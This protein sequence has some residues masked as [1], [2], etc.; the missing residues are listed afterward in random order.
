VL[1]GHWWGGLRGWLCP[2][3][4]VPLTSS[5]TGGTVATCG[6][7]QRRESSTQPAAIWLTNDAGTNWTDANGGLETVPPSSGT[8]LLTSIASSADGQRLAAIRNS[9]RERGDEILLFQK[10]KWTTADG[11]L[12][13]LQY[14]IS[15]AICPRNLQRGEKILK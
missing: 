12:P 5:A 3:R 8:G 6:V 14:L 4:T 10:G 7:T 9:D 13:D 1:A 15:I 11:P 2:G